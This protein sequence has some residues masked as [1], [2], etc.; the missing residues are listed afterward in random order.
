MRSRLLTS[1]ATAL[2]LAFTSARAAELLIHPIQDVLVS[3]NGE[4][5][6][7]RNLGVSN[8]G[9]EYIR[10]TFLQFDLS[11]IPAGAQIE[12]VVLRLIPSGY[13]GKEN[14]PIP[15]A[16]W[17]FTEPV[18]WH[19]DGITWQNSPKRDVLFEQGYGEPGV[20]RLAILDWDAKIDV[21]KRPP[22]LFTGENLT[23]FVR[24]FVG[25]PVTL[26]V[27]CEG[28]AKTPGLV[29]FS[30]DNRPVA[31]SVYPALLVTTK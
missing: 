31:K 26:V 9:P 5:S 20:A 22:L 23:A 27:I 4:L 10:R 3:S 30:K 17:G 24:R 25:K 1:L 8:R 2:L 15:L 12:K 13:I 21:T 11:T 7:P 18:S 29:F 6:E 19:E 28:G 16:L 14:T